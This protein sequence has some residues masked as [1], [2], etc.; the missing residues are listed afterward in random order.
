[1]S[2]ARSHRFLL[3]VAGLSTI[4]LAGAC[5][6]KPLPL[7]L[8]LLEE[9]RMDVV[10][11]EPPSAGAKSRG[12]P[13][14]LVPFS[15]EPLW[16][17]AR[18]LLSFTRIAVGAESAR[19]LS[20]YEPSKE[21]YLDVASMSPQQWA[22]Y[23]FSP[24]WHP[25]GRAL[26]FKSR[27]A[28]DSGVFAAVFQRQRTV[29][30]LPDPSSQIRELCWAA[31][32]LLFTVQI[33]SNPGSP[34]ELRYVALPPPDQIAPDDPVRLAGTSRILGPGR[35]PR[36]HAGLVYFL[37]ETAR[38]SDLIRRSL[39][40]SSKEE[41]LASGVGPA[42]VDQVAIIKNKLRRLSA[43]IHDKESVMVHHL[44][45]WPEFFI[46]VLEEIKN[47]EVRKNDRDFQV[48]DKVILQE[49][50]PSPCQVC[51]FQTPE[52]QACGHQYTRREVTVKITYILG[53]GSI[54]ALFDG[55]PIPSKLCVFGFYVISRRF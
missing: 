36:F 40:E 17:P 26:A 12:E 38:G 52:V 18:T 35:L 48:G 32:G 23:G 42:T 55:A 27:S 31:P 20:L 33:D 2:T 11:L 3:F 34:F 53:A 19:V 37:R 4:L 44:K 21:S 39:A 41:T 45:S 8:T 29:K 24:A 9:N 28:Q 47:F 13:K 25:S 14:T 7:A 5:A 30:L 22:G 16:N 54:S 43:I 46:P 10:L 1:M 49:Y 50:Y 15:F 6:R 51:A